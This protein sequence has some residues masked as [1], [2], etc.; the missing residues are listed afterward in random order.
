MRDYI[1]YFKWLYIIFAALLLIFG[2]LTAGHAITA[3][4]AGYERTNTEC[5]T[6]ERVFDYGDVLTDK[7]E[8]KL[9]KLIAKRE[10]QTGCDIVLV[11]LKESLKDYARMIEP[12]VRYSEFVRVYAEDFY[13]SNNF[14]Y[15]KPNG[16]GMILVDNWYREDDGRIYTWCCAGGRVESAYSD[17]DIDYLLDN[18]YVYVEKNPYRA[19]KTYV[20][21]FYH[22]MMG[23]NVVH[24]NVPRS[25]PWFA[26]IIA[27]VIFIIINLAG[28]KGAKTTTAHTYVN[29]KEPHFRVREDRF[30]RKSVTQ[31][32]I[33]SSSSGGSHG[34]GHSG[35][36]HGGS[37]RGG[38]H[39]R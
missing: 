23:I 26:G 30:L 37:H 4:A 6:T 31:R 21:D 2:M 12:N 13:E 17:A 18:V 36:S 5:T 27:S 15:D 29:G 32:K 39:S 35:S 1:R 14:G 38:G 10:K 24:V 9:R 28:R 19:Y 8:A 7:E 22:D 11:T 25:V 20:N 16:D 34:G 33:E 3:G